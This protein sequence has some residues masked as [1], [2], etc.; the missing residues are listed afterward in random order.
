MTLNTFLYFAGQNDF[1]LSFNFY[2]KQAFG[3]KKEYS[4]VTL[5]LM[6]VLYDITYF[7]SIGLYCTQ[8]KAVNPGISLG[9]NNL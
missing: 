6:C 7:C 3:T 9:S 4:K 8:I 5:M 2:L 1:F